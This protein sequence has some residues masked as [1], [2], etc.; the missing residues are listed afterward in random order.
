MA[1]DFDAVHVHSTWS[2]PT[3]VASLLALRKQTRLIISPHGS[4]EPYDV[5]KH[6]RQKQLLGPLF[7]RPLLNRASTVLCTTHQ[8]PT[9]W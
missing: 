3:I 5:R 9:A 1:N 7:V 8:R 6:A 2:I 4:L